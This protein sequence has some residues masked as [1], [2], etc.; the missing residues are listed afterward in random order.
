MEQCVSDSS[1]YAVIAVSLAVVFGLIGAIQLIGPRFARAAYRRWDY[2]QRLRVL[3][4]MLDIAAAF[5]LAVPGLRGW[6]IALA[7]I[8]TFGSV[9]IFLSHRQYRYAVP[10][11]G[12]MVA[13]V[14]AAVAI[15][16]PGPVQFVVQRQVSGEVSQTVAAADT[17]TISASSVE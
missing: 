12:L 7:A 14:P 5:M 6:G 4:G 15:P 10:A 16:R 9:I 11:I 2:P 8:L 13:L 3:T 1:I 17:T